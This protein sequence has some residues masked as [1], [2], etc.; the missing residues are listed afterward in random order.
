MR[1]REEASSQPS[2]DAAAVSHE[3]SHDQEGAG[4]T[5][6]ISLHTCHELIPL[7]VMS[8]DQKEALEEGSEAV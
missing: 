5:N 6:L 2:C 4:Q 7:T 3:R 1:S 8:V